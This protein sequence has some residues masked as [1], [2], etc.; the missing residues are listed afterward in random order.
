MV[1][2]EK[3][4]QRGLAVERFVSPGQRRIDEDRRSRGVGRWERLGRGSAPARGRRM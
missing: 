3:V 1:W 4:I 2:E